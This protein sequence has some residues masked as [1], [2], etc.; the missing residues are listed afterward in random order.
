MF[1]FVSY[2]ETMKAVRN[3]NRPPSLS[4]LREDGLFATLIGLFY[5]LPDGCAC[6]AAL[7]WSASGSSGIFSC[8]V[9]ISFC[10]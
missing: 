1:R 2:M 3:S 10:T 6:C 8:S 9:S 5:L 7:Y 4:K